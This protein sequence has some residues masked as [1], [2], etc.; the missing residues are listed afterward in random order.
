MIQTI[1][2][3]LTDPVFIKT[4]VGETKIPDP[5]ILPTIT[6]TP[7]RR[8]ILGLR[9]ISSSPA[10][11]EEDILII[12]FQR[13]TLFQIGITLLYCTLFIVSYADAEIFLQQSRR[14]GC[15]LMSASASVLA[16]KHRK[17]ACL[18]YPTRVCPFPLWEEMNQQ[19]DHF[20]V[21]RKHNIVINSFDIS[22]NVFQQLATINIYINLCSFIRQNLSTIKI[23]ATLKSRY[24][25]LRSM[26]CAEF[27][28]L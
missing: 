16:W 12:L 4:P 8:L 7:L 25:F 10:F 22:F 13:F 1:R 6:V 15:V 20:C 14:F 27:K 2:A 11:G 18:R 23:I 17:S 3:A 19:L 24:I 5:I 28:T 21:I 26:T 9:V